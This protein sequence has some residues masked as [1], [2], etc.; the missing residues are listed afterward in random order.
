VWLLIIGAVLAAWA[1]VA[2]AWSN[3]VT[4]TT[5][6]QFTGE[7]VDRAHHN[8][9]LTTGMRHDYLLTVRTDDG[10]QMTC[11]VNPAVFGR[12]VVGDRIVKHAGR[13]WP[14]PA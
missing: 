10:E 6:Q 4:A 2:I 3:R 12:F 5:A 11:D 9:T 8:V 1:G 7:V 14:E 13:R